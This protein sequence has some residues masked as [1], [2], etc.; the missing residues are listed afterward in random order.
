MDLK[1]AGQSAVI[2]GAGGAIGGA[3]AEVLVAE[4]A[5]VAIWDISKEAA[6]RRAETLC[7]DGACAVAVGCDAMDSESV[8][9][10]LSTTLE[11]FE[12]V[13][14][15]VNAAGGSRRETTTSPELSFFDLDHQ[16]MQSVVG[17]NYFGTVLPCQA[18]GKLMAGQGD[19]SI[20]NI[21]SIAGMQPLTR[22]ITY[23]NAKAA[24][25]SFT[26]WLAVHMAREYSPRIRVNAIAP[27]FLLTEQNRFLLVNPDTGELTD[28]GRDIMAQVPMQ[29]FGTP[30]EIAGLAAWLASPLSG[31]ATGAVIPVDGGFTAFSGV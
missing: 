16:A 12:T 20:V 31:F 28:R 1:L 15:L 30:D 11:T 2:T 29:R 24:V 19:G 21:G 17:L 18:V 13:D 8:K 26:Q 3:I 6:T 5:C 4:G 23:S 7:R 10:A 22:A 25:A 27:G 9:E 14:I